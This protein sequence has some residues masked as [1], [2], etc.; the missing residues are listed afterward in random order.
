M[1]LGFAVTLLTLLAA[2]SEGCG[3]RVHY[4]YRGYAYGYGRHQY[5]T[6]TSTS[7]GSSGIAWNQPSPAPAPNPVNAAPAPQNAQSGDVEVTGSDGSYGWQRSCNADVEIH[8]LS[9]KM[10]KRGCQFE[11][12]GYDETKAIC[13]GVHVLL[14]RDATNI[15]RLCPPN[16]ERAVC[17]Q[18][19]APVIA[20]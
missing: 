9:E 5:Y 1:R 6:A 16:A 7:Y 20:P 4:T 8:A 3:V 18:A 10:A 2:F 14:R 13:S 12:Y 19:W 11:S 15:Y 17:Q